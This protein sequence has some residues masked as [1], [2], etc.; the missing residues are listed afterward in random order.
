MHTW[1]WIVAANYQGSTGIVLEAS[2]DRTIQRFET[3]HAGAGLNRYTR[4]AG[5]HWDGGLLDVARA[6]SVR[7]GIA[8]NGQ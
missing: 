4:S 7:R 8:R 5:R 6:A 2:S 1:T 3:T